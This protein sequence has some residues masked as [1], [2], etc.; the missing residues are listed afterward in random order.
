MGNRYAPLMYSTSPW[1]P[2]RR[3]PV[4][5]NSHI[6]C[7]QRSTMGRRVC[8]MCV[9]PTMTRARRGRLHAPLVGG[10]I[11]CAISTAAHLF[12]AALLRLSHP[13][14]K[15]DTRCLPHSQIRRTPDTPQ[16]VSVPPRDN[17]RKNV[18]RETVRRETAMRDGHPARSRSLT[19]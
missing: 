17:A 5:V 6:S 16:R 14:V 13:P 8:V 15:R 2:P 1:L 10:Y 19:T 12:V 3:T 4:R 9:R 18:L 11:P 7:G